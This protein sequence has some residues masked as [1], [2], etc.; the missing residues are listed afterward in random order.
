MRYR[1]RAD[2]GR[3]LAEELASRWD[4][5]EP[6][7]V[8]G[9]PR[10]GVPVAV[11]VAQRLGADLDVLMAHKLGAPSNPE[12]AI[13]A[14]A[15]DGTVV[16]DESVVG[17]L[18]VPKEYIDGEIERQR[19]SLEAKSAA[20]RSGRDPK[21]V[22]GRDVIVV[23]DGIATGATLEAAVGLLRAAG[24]RTITIAAPVAPP[25]SVRRLE[26]VADRVVC[27]S[28]PSSFRAVG[29]WYDDFDQTTDAEV[30]AALGG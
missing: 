4:S 27:P 12:F 19:A 20:Y 29:L 9:V 15:E 23:D 11:E 6:P 25:D 8:L 1:D 17:W 16:L 18:R 13:G 21:P 5:A 24:A 7:L 26:R 10:G 22:T 14:L 28:Q 30:I 3:R 2:A